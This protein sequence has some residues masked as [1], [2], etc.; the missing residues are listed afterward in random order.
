MPMVQANVRAVRLVLL[1]PPGAGKGTQAVRLARR[2]GVPHI[3]TGEIF[4]SA[5]AAGTSLGRAAEHFL[6]AGELLPDR[7]VTGLVHA[8]LTQPD[9]RCGFILDGFP[10]TL[11]QAEAFA[12]LLTARNQPLAR[13]VWLEVPDDRLITRLSGRGQL[14]HRSDDRAAVIRR[15]LAVYREET[16]PLL[17]YYATRELLTR[18]DGLGTVEEVAD[19]ITAALADGT[20]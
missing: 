19:R 10:R 17:A 20:P 8:R 9:A 14:L 12:G 4:R 15:R 11:P 13:V 16:A 1:G 7:V 2:F 6:A 5:V 18:V 3:A